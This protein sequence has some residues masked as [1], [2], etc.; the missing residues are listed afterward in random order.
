MTKAKTAVARSSVAAQPSQSFRPSKVKNVS[1]T[2]TI[3]ARNRRPVT[4]LRKMLPQLRP[5]RTISG[6]FEISPGDGADVPSPAG[7]SALAAASALGAS[8][9]GDST[10]GGVWALAVELGA[11]LGAGLAAGTSFGGGG[12]ASIKRGSSRLKATGG[13]PLGAPLMIVCHRSESSKLYRAGYVEAARFARIQ[14]RSA[15]AAE[16]GRNERLRPPHPAIPA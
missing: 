10:L 2:Q 4:A 15:S 11:A 9:L 5:T 7:A 14:D 13:L 16:N 12:G 8:T 1:W 3:K 6:T